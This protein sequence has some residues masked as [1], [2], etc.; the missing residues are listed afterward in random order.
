MKVLYVVR[1]FP[2]FT[3]G[4]E[5]VAQDL[6]LSLSNQASVGLVK[7]KKNIRNP[8]VLPLIMGK[9]LVR[10]IRD[11]PEIIYLQDGLLSPLVVLGK[12]FGI[13][14]VVQTHGLDITY[15]KLGYQR[16][17]IPFLRKADLITSV[18]RATKQECISRR[19]DPNHVV[20]IP[21]GVNFEFWE[22][23][24]HINKVNGDGCKIPDAPYILSVGRLIERK[25]YHWFLKNVMPEIWRTKPSIK[26]VIVGE[27]PMGHELTRLIEEMGCGEKV[28]MLGRV[29]NED[30][31]EIFKNATVFVSPNIEVN[32]DLEGFGVANIEATFFS[33]P[34]IANAV[35]GVPDAIVEGVTGELVE[36][37]HPLE[38]AKKVVQ[39]LDS[40]EKYSKTH[41]KKVLYSEYSWE[42]VSD[43]FLIEFHKVKDAKKKSGLRRN[44]VFMKE[45]KN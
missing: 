22:E 11:K 32:G 26:Y 15:S 16:L 42:N 28:I 29:N 45:I 30:L 27:G 23:R 1:K 12:V 4:M 18:S 31:G 41:M 20:V 21:N 6:Y 36:K 3:G 39:V 44:E 17:I 7:P 24:L 37:D 5:R 19:V 43:K 9:M 14:V 35:D 25:G 2:P 33:V 34:I 40:P 38:F 10:M 13:P 8:L